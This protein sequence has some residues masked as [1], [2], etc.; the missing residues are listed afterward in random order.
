MKYRKQKFLLLIIVGLLLLASC[1][2]NTAEGSLETD[3]SSMFQKADV[4][5]C[6]ITAEETKVKAGLGSR[7]STITTL[8]KGDRVKVLSEIGNWYVIRL[9]DNQLG[10][11]RSDDAEPIVASDGQGDRAED[12]QPD[13]T[14]D[15]APDRNQDRAPDENTPDNQDRNDVVGDEPSENDPADEPAP[16]ANEPGR[17]GNEPEPVEQPQEPQP[18]SP[19]NNNDQYDI[20]PVDSLNSMERNMLERVNEERRK[21]DL[22][23]LSIDYRLTKV[24]RIKAQDMVD[25]DYFSHY[26]PTYGSPFDMMNKFG[27]EYIQAAEN[28][29]GNSSVERAHNSLM[30]SSGHRQNILNPGFTHIGIGVKA[31]DRYGYIFVQMFIKK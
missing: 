14:G 22:T 20:D 8:N 27:I 1:N 18:D 31:S 23:P 6:R 4:Q 19:Q 7:Y 28:L 13:R 24:A 17:N 11:I 21:N 3:K 9:N 30:G 15:D 2:M 25:N 5:Y 16:G 29:A 26:S 10:A 12:N